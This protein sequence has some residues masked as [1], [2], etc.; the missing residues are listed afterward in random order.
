M[1]IRSLWILALI[2]AGGAALLTLSSLWFLLTDTVRRRSPMAWIQ[3]LLLSAGAILFFLYTYAFIENDRSNLRWPAILCIT[4]SALLSLRER[5]WRI[6]ESRKP[7]L[8]GNSPK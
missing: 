3:G 8:P 6:V 5:R 1:L 2:V 4:A 7:S